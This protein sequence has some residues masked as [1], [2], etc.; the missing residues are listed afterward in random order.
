MKKLIVLVGL[1]IVNFAYGQNNIAQQTY[2]IFEA[3][4]LDCHGE[5]GKFKETLFMT[6]DNL[7]EKGSVIPSDP[8]ASELYKRLLASTDQGARMP[9]NQPQLPPEFIATIRQWI[10]MGASDWAVTIGDRAFITQGTMMDTIK[11]HLDTLN[12]FDRSYARYFSMT[13]LYNVGEPLDVLADYQL[14]L[15]KL[16]NSLSWELEIVN[17]QPVDAEQTIYYIDLRDYGWDKS[18]AWTELEQEYLYHIAYNAPEQLH[19]NEKLSSLQLEISSK[20]PVIHI[21]WFIGNASLPPLYHDILNLPETDFELEQRLGIDVVDNLLNAPGQSVW[22]AGFSE[23]KVSSNNR[24]IERHVSPY[25]AYWKSYDFAGSVGRQNIFVHPISFIHDGGEVVFSLP[26]G[27]QAYYLSNAKSNRLDVAPIDIVSNP[28]ASDQRVRNG[29]SCIGCHTEGMKTFEDTVRQAIEQTPVTLYNKEHALQLYVEQ[30]VMDALVEGDAKRYKDALEQTG[31][32]IGGIE[33]IHRFYEAFQK[34]V[35]T[36]HAAAALGLGTET[37]IQKINGN[38]NLQSLGLNVFSNQGTIKRDIWTARFQEIVYILDFPDGSIEKPDDFVGQVVPIGYVYI[39]DPNLRAIIEVLL[40]K[41]QGAPITKV[42]MATLKEIEDK[43]ISSMNGLECAINLTKLKLN[44][45]GISDIG[46]VANMENLRALEM[47]GNPIS[48]ISPMRELTQLTYIEFSGSQLSDI[49]PIAGLVNL[50]RVQIRWASLTDISSLA[51]LTSLERLDLYHN[52][53]LV[54]ISPVANLTNLHELNLSGCHSIRD[55]SP[56]ANLTN[57]KTIGLS[58]NVPDISSLFKLFPCTRIGWHFSP[59]LPSDVNEDGVINI[60]DLVAVA[61]DFGK[62]VTKESRTD[63]NLDGVI[64]I[65]DLTR[66]A[67]YFG[68]TCEVE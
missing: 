48:D 57:L 20:V 43:N 2:A 60:L 24:V 12:A 27:L 28:A 54:D 50:N 67:T 15:N 37:F 40:N 18:N 26:N 23:S 51:G 58:R 53:I 34:P 44:K 32:T 42:E 30:S 56:I 39:P 9:F 11:T 68:A 61:N 19:L 64:N 14:A 59:S 13:H 8:D 46:P 62:S 22:R 52:E 31:G 6:Y 66:V 1:L 10:E 29:L 63:I 5:S 35:T 21:D 41:P 3:H 49:S 47:P 17:P 4:C 55:V 36:A 65:L 38:I 33:P 7:I 25:G 16:V 45:N